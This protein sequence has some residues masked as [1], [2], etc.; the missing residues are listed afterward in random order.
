MSAISGRGI[1]VMSTTRRRIALG[2]TAAASVASMLALAVPAQ[3]V[4][5]VAPV[6]PTVGRVPTGCDPGVTFGIIG[7]SSWHFGYT[8]SGQ[9]VV[10]DVRVSAN[11]TNLTVVPPAGV[12]LNYSVNVSE[13]CSGVVQV[14]S[15]IA[16]NK[17]VVAL[18]A[19]T[20][21]TANAFS[22]WWSLS[23]GNKL[24]DDAVGVWTVPLAGVA[25]RYDTFTLDQDFKVVGSPVAGSASRTITGAWAT[26]PSYVVR[27]M[28]LSNTLSAAKV[29]KGK[30]VKA[31][32]VLKM[33]TNSGYLADA[34]DKVVV[35]T[36][37]GAG[38][39][40]SHATL[41]TNASGVVSYSFV[42]TAT[43][44]VRFVHNKVLSGKFTNAV[45][46]AIKTVTKV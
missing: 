15:Y 27:A 14:A 20:N 16:R 2:I 28:T 40:V 11:A 9:P 31:T 43:T 17:T 18:A 44:Q 3:A 8:D 37:V 5:P 6:W 24:P 42:L 21:T 38:K 46:S 32:A 30:T 35:Q 41:T 13:P 33:A 34:S 26:K 29:K 39:W 19:Y 1:L 4:T 22:S 7:P 25:R 36:K 12:I 23:A 45:T 10:N